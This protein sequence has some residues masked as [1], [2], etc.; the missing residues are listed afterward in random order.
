MKRLP[1]LSGKE[2][3]K[4]VEKLGFVFDHQTGS[5]LV[6]KHLDGRVS[7]I[8]YHSGEEIGSGLLNKIIKKDLRMSREEF[9]KLLKSR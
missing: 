7:V 5:H 8:P 6:Y 3:G 2:L 4:V 1:R 9:L